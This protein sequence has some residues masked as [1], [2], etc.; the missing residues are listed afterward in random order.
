[1]GGPCNKEYSILG[2]TLGSPYLGTLPNSFSRGTHVG[3][4][5]NNDGS[6]DAERYFNCKGD[7]YGCFAKPDNA[8]QQQIKLLLGGSGGHSKCIPRDP[9]VQIIPT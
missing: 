5:G 2:S 4:P 7:K 8:A 6:K 9:S 1:M 3:E